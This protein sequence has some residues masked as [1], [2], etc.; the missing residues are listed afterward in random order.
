MRMPSASLQYCNAG[1]RTHLFGTTF[2]IELGHSPGTSYGNDEGDRDRRLGTG[3]TEIPNLVES[4]MDGCV[5]LV[6]DGLASAPVRG[7][8][9]SF[10]THS[11]LDVFEVR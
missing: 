4:V 1:L 3:G 10:L 6:P 5:D 9:L 7:R 11:C 8:G 2:G